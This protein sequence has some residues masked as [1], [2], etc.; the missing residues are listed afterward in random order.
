[1]PLIS[2]LQQVMGVWL[3]AQSL[4]SFGLGLLLSDGWLD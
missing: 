4:W 3:D 2:S 1:M